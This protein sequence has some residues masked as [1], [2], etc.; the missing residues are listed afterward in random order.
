MEFIE[1]NEM[2]FESFA[3]SHPL[4]T[5]MQTKEIAELRKSNGYD[6][7]YVGVKKDNKIVCA[8]MMSSIK[9]YFG[10]KKF[11]A[12]RGFL[13]DYSDKEL[14]SFFTKEIK[15]YIKSKKGYILRIDPYLMYH[16]RDINGD[17]VVGGINNEETVETLLEL[18]YKKVPEKH[19]EQVSWMF[20]LDVKGKTKEEIFSNMK[21]NTRNIIR[22][23]EKD[24]INIRELSYDELPIF[25]DVM[26]STAKRREFVNRDLDYYQKMYKLFKDKV[27][28]LVSELDVDSYIKSLNLKIESKEKELENLKDTKSNS[29]KRKELIVDIESKKKKKEE[30]LLLKK[31]K[32]NKII[33]SASMFILTKPEVVYLF[34]GNYKQ[35]MNFKSQYLIQWHMIKFAID[36]NYD[37]YNFYGI[38][39]N[40]NTNPENYDL[41]K[42]KKSFDGYVIELIGEYA[43]PINKMYYIIEI[44]KKI[45]R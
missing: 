35:Y 30:A 7:Y 33:L 9:S 10:Y 13:I 18:G 5:F 3:S 29:G 1:L 45:K 22:N 2:E 36:N 20:A 26:E 12:P 28:Y 11:Y 37:R 16:E 24:N 32:G 8:T 4:R 27:K 39:S 38:P 34:S 23:L 43:L 40:I 19:F 14:V 17:I 25:M 31:E 15:K 42:F 6:V 21:Q 41:Y 44:I